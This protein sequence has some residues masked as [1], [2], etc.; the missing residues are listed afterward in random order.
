MTGQNIGAL[1]AM[2]AATRKETLNTPQFQAY[3]V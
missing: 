2:T 1:I 3:A